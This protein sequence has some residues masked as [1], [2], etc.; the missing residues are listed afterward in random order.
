[1]KLIIGL[2]IFAMY[3]VCKNFDI[4]DQK[5]KKEEIKGLLVENVMQP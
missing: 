5:I 1:M 3:F 4:I 2:P